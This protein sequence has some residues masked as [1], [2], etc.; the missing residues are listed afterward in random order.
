[1]GQGGNLSRSLS[2]SNRG[3]RFY[4]D[5]DLDKVGNDLDRYLDQGTLNAKRLFFGKVFK[6]Q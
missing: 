5:R 4:L 2:R 6:C 3:G 1:M